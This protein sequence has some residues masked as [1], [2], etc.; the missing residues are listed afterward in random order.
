MKRI[1]ILILMLSGFFSMHNAMADDKQ[2]SPSSQIGEPSPTQQWLELQRSGK[3][4]S[5]QAQPISGEVMDKVHQRY[6][7]S[8][9]K[10]IPEFYE[11]ETPAAR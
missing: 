9:D 2:P 1:I 5:L 8:F 6:L 4:A 11:H 10:P 3:S 7:K